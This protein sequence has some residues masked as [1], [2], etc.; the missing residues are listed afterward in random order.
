MTAQV[1]YFRKPKECPKDW[2]TIT[3]NL[4]SEGLNPDR[5][6]LAPALKEFFQILDTNTFVAKD[7]GEFQ[8][9]RSSM[10]KELAIL[11]VLTNPEYSGGFK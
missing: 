2:L 4:F 9:F 8:Y 1:I 7:D 3:A 10:P 11:F 5:S 6:K